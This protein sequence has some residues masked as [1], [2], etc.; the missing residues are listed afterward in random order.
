MGTLG[1]GLAA[2]DGPVR[3]EPPG[4]GRRVDLDYAVFVRDVEP[5]LSARG[6]SNA[7]CHGGQ[8]SGMLLL[9]NGSNPEADFVSIANHTYPWAPSQ[10]PLVR[11]PLAV[12]AGGDVHGGGDIF[13]DSLDADYRTL[14]Q[15]IEAAR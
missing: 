5:I 6:C 3:V 11:K 7:A 1:V 12:G 9:S 8:G 2:C 13:A 14:L 10:S 15:W 4:G